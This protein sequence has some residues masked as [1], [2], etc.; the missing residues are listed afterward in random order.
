MKRVCISYPSLSLPLPLPLPPPPPLSQPLLISL[1]FFSSWGDEGWHLGKY[2]IVSLW[3]VYTVR[4][5]TLTMTMALKTLGTPTGARGVQCGHGGWGV[6]HILRRTWQ[7]STELRHTAW[8][9]AHLGT[10]DLFSWN[11]PCVHCL[12]PRLTTATH[13]MMK[14]DWGKISDTNNAERVEL[15]HEEMRAGEAQSTSGTNHK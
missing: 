14:E 15:K 8:S 7:G 2:S 9:G 6:T 3:C 12:K 11:F 13:I 1:Y 5:T 10:Y 4:V